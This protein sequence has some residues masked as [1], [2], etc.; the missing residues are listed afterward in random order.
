M[1]LEMTMAA[2]STGPRRRSSAGEEGV[3][4]KAGRRYLVRSRRWI[5]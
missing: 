5:L 1:T 2:A 3:T 4:V